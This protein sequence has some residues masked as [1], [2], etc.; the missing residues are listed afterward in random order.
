MTVLPRRLSPRPSLAGPKLIQRHPAATR[1]RKFPGMRPKPVARSR[2]A[3]HPGTSPAIRRR[4]TVPRPAQSKPSARLRGPSRPLIQKRRYNRRP[5]RFRKPKAILR[6]RRPWRRWPKVPWYDRTW[7]GYRW[8]SYRPWWR[9]YPLDW[10]YGPQAGTSATTTF[11]GLEKFRPQARHALRRQGLLRGAW[12]S[13]LANC[14]N[15]LTDFINRFYS[16]AGFEWVVRDELG[17]GYPRCT[18]RLAA[19]LAQRLADRYPDFAQRMSFER[20]LGTAP[21]VESLRS[22][23]LTFDR[24]HYQLSPWSEL[25]P[26]SVR[27]QFKRNLLSG[28]VQNTRWVFDATRLGRRKAEIVRILRSILEKMPP[29]GRRLPGF[30]KGLEALPRQVIILD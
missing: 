29:T 20:V 4:R 5:R 2:P 8:L 15:R 28:P 24:R 16:T 10:V 1:L 30:Q 25:E 19:R 9:R 7:Y 14:S 17:G 26:A 21:G 22:L 12:P 18:A 6:R 23:A 27:T 3:T 11:P 13:R